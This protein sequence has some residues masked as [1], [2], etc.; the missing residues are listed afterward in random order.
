MK[1]KNVEATGTDIVDQVDIEE[2]DGE[3]SIRAKWL[4]DG[5]TTLTEAAQQLRAYADDLLQL[6]KQGWQLIGPVEDD[7]GWISQAPATTRE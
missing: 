5:A 3:E 1:A 6:E 2:T 4:M 7:Y